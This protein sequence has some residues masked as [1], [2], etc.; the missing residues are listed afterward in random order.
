[1]PVLGAWAL[2]GAGSAC[3]ARTFATAHAHQAL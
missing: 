3:L 2:V 1:M